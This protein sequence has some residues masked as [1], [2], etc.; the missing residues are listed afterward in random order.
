MA[1]VSFTLACLIAL[2]VSWLMDLF[3]KSDV[4]NI[5]ATVIVFV[6]SFVLLEGCFDKYAFCE[7]A[8]LKICPADR[9]EYVR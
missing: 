9:T 2:A 4:A 5:T 6:I 3:G 1:I 7:S 8:V